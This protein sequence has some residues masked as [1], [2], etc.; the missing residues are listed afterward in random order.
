MSVCV[1]E[2]KGGTGTQAQPGWGEA[3]GWQE[4][5]SALRAYSQ[6]RALGDGTTVLAR[7]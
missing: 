6:S 5:D 7:T 3:C 4:A 1:Y 2:G